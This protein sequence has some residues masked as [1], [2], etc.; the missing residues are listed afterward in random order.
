LQ[1][2]I[3]TTVLPPTAGLVTKGNNATYA[4]MGW[5]CVE[6]IKNI[7]LGDYALYDAPSEQVRNRD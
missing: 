5:P 1:I 4:N 2:L 6:G 7:V 3:K